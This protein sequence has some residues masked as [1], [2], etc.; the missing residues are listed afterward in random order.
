M[1]H[2]LRSLHSENDFKISIVKKL[3][4][5]EKITEEPLSTSVVFRF[6][7]TLIF[8]FNIKS[9]IDKKSTFSN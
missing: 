8:F 5:F 9:K 3:F 7:F 4:K 2:F 1:S 6:S